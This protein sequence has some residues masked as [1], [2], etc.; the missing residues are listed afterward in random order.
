VDLASG[1]S[2]DR[3]ICPWQLEKDADGMIG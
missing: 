1:C 2:D 3:E